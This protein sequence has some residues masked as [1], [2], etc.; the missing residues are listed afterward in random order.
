MASRIVRAKVAK[1]PTRAAAPP[2]N[3]TIPPVSS[4]A[5]A[6]RGIGPGP[7]VI[8]PHRNSPPSL[9]GSTARSVTTVPFVRLS[10]VLDPLE[11]AL[12]WLVALDVGQRQRFNV[13]RQSHMPNRQ[14]VHECRQQ[15]QQPE[16]GQGRASQHG[17]SGE[18]SRSLAAGPGHSWSAGSH[19]VGASWRW[20]GGT[21]PV[22]SVSRS[23][24]R[25]LAHLAQVSPAR[26]HLICQ[27]PRRCRL[28]RLVPPGKRVRT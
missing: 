8:T 9:P 25:K 20:D 27:A 11:P 23:R 15:E 26:P 3:T 5:Q 2:K 6:Q 4:S 12:R 1:S 28:S 22:R 16:A 10:V 13:L 7:P 24:A 19:A 21:R 18:T 17:A 14:H